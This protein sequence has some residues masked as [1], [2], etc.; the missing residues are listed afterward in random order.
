MEFEEL[1]SK[2][3]VFIKK[4]WLPLCLGILGLIF[5]L[6]GLISLLSE[7]QINR[8]EFSQNA[9]QNN[10]AS[11]SAVLIAIDIEGAIEAPGVYMLNQGSLLKDALVA[12]KGLSKL[13][14]REYVSKN[15]NLASKLS[16]GQKIYIPKIGEDMTTSKNLSPN[17]S[18]A[19]SLINI[20]T[21]SAKDLDSLPGVGPVTAEK[22]IQARPF[23]TIDELVSKKIVSSKVFE[24]IKDLI[25]AY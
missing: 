7:K 13:A 23:I 11:K 14:D 15:I 24:E 22:I 20:N 1:S 5:I 6:Y 18:S 9:S 17:T 10:L 4:Y 8:L 16:D 21:A 12:A 2:F 25:S 19:G 3:I